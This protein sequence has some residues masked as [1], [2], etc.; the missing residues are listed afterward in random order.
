MTS[1]FHTAST[2]QPQ[3]A[4]V[5]RNGRHRQGR[6]QS[7]DGQTAAWLPVV[8]IAQCIS[9]VLFAGVCE[10]SGPGLQSLLVVPPR[11]F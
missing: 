10:S 2:S 3:D 5:T 1:F 6:P 9:I 11:P 7:S 8:C 4:N